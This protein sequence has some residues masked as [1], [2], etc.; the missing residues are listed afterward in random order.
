MSTF[1]ETPDIIS[2]STHNKINVLSPSEVET[3]KNGTLRLLSEVGVYYSSQKALTIFADHGAD[4]DWETK[5]VR[6]PPDLVIKA[7]G[8]APRSFVLGGREEAFDLTLD[9][10][11]ILS[12]N[13]WLWRACD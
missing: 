11:C 6:I 5:I 2:I 9:G 8:T 3:L 1:S 10:I 12:G 4:V 13:G 7:M